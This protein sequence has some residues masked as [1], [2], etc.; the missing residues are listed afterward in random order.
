MSMLFAATYPERTIALLRFGTVANFTI[1]E[2]AYK[3]D[4][5]AYLDRMERTWGTVEQARTE[6]ADW[7][8]PSHADDE[9]PATWLASYLRRAASPGAAIA[10]ERMNSEINVGHALPSIH[11]PTLVLAKVDDRD[12]DIADVMTGGI[13]GARLVELPGT[14]T[15]SG[16]G[17]TWTC[18]KR[19]VA[20]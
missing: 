17:S 19:S 18:S 12:F 8:A 11:V 9:R 2:P 13:A 1:R 4:V 10:I 3:Q 20:S 15:S 5:G 16:P 7:G 14:S 6:I